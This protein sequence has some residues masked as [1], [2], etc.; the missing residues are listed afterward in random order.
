MEIFL[1]TIRF[2]NMLFYVGLV[3]KKYKLTT[4]KQYKCIQ[5]K[6][7]DNILKLYSCDG[8]H[9]CE[10]IYGNVENSK[11][12]SCMIEYSLLDDIVSLSDAQT[13]KLKFRDKSLLLSDNGNEYKMQYVE[14]YDFSFLVENI[15]MDFKDPIAKLETWQLKEVT[16]FISCCFPKKDEYGHLR[17]VYFD[18]NFV[19]TNIISC[20]VFSQ[21]KMISK[22]IFMSLN[23]FLILSSIT[24]D[25]PFS[26]YN[27]GGKFVIKNNEATYIL[28][29]MADKFP[30]YK[31]V[32]DIVKNHKYTIVLDRNQVH[33][34]CKK[35]LHFSDKIYRNSSKIVLSKED[36]ISIEVL[37]G[38]KEGKEILKLKE[39]NVDKNIEFSL[40][41]SHLLVYIGNI[42]S[43]LIYLSFNDT[44]NEIG[45]GDND[46]R[47]YIET[48]LK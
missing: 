26:L 14:N 43:E 31:H 28:T 18:G 30:N 48:T 3:T 47:L 15:K 1:D 4:N 35:L 44:P 6:F 24:N 33:K 29:V 32:F 19:A 23:S 2:S 17:G 39:T 27:D 41:I 10:T 11:E 9:V 22:P 8:V 16:S 7:K 38:E 12:F 37:S 20:S 36:S 40:N 34:A 25:E 5:F 46:K 13:I 21:I 45:I 42:N